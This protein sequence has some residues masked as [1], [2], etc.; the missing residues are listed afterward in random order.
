MT[1]IRTRLL[2]LLLPPLIGFILVLGSIIY[3]NRHE[4]L[5]VI[6]ALGLG[7]LLWITGSVWFISYKISE[8]VQKLK[9]A[10]LILASGH[11]E[12]S[13]KVDGPKEIMELAGTLNTMRECLL[14]HISRLTDYPVAREKLYGEF[15]CAELI[16][17]EMLDRTLEKMYESHYAIR[18][19]SLPS[20]SLFG[21]KL[22]WDGESLSLSEAEQEGFSGIYKLLTEGTSKELKINMSTGDYTSTAFTEPLF[23]SAKENKLVPMQPLAPGDILVIYSSGLTRQMP[24]PQILKNWLS[25][26]L[27]YFAKD[28]LELTSQMVRSELNFFAKKYIHHEDIHIL[29]ITLDD[30]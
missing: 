10:A 1:T 15:E 8:P 30:R 22:N 25:K 9:D 24:H 27:K 5:S 2:M 7:S 20:S 6:I 28:G 21:L 13:I 18:K 12:D 3:F 4:D 14:E 26:I 16:Q 17:F 23:W 29:M 19:A 11:Y